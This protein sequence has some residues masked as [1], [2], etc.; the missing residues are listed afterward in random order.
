L[1]QILKYNS[2]KMKKHSLLFLLLLAVGVIACKDDDT[3]GPVVPPSELEVIEGNITANMT[4]DATK[5]YLLRGKVFVQAPNTLTIPAGTVIFG[6]K[7]TDGTLII[8]RGAKIMAQGT[9]ERPIVMTSQAPIGFRNRGDWGGVV[10]L[11]NAHT[12]NPATSPIEGIGAT[13]TENGVYGPGDGAAQNEQNSGVMTYTRIEFAGI[14]LS[15][16]NELNSLTMGGVGSGTEIHHI[17][18]TYANDD[19]YEWF[20]GTVNHKYLIAYSTLDDD[21]DS[22]RGYTGKV[23]YGLIVRIPGV[24]DVSTSRAFEA[25][26]NNDATL[27]LQSAPTFANITVL[28]PR[29]YNSSISGSYG[30][31]VEINSNSS[32]K[33]Y[34]SLI[35]GFPIGVRFNGSGP[36]AEVMNNVFVDNTSYATTSGG[37]TVPASFESGNIIAERAAVFGEG[38]TYNATTPSPLFLSSNSPYLSGAPNLNAM[39]SFFDQQPFYGAFGADGGAGWNLNAAWVEWNPGNV[40]Y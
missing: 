10:I 11:G 7:D 6:E 29:L 36:G 15:Q 18:I 2:K 38:A 17:M 28:G 35:T 20:G 13:G 14:D 19:A 3:G 9:A 22:D 5:K 31:A 23:Q 26:S 24:A 1:L 32:M 30:A 40:E 33:L 27:A 34:N 12:N 8:N 4:L 39:D 37:S 21:F 16:D 25:S